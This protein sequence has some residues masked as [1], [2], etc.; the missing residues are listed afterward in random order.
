MTSYEQVY[1]VTVSI[2]INDN[3]VAYILFSF[4]I[5]FW[6][7]GIYIHAQGILYSGESLITQRPPPEIACIYCNGG[8]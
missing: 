4:I 2:F 1:A 5:Y 3:G 8:V 6:L 7:N